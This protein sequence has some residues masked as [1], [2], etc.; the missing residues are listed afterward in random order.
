MISRRVRVESIR[1]IAGGAQINGMP[2]NEG[3]CLE[4]SYD[5][6]AEHRVTGSLVNYVHMITTFFDINHW[7]NSS[8]R[9]INNLRATVV[10][11]EPT[12]SWAALFAQLHNACIGKTIP[13]PEGRMSSA[14][15][16]T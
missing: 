8:P 7:Q 16:R 10:A 4:P 6:R 15:N 3:D 9:Q 1:N 13:Q 14:D 2:Y 12:W 5:E 11:P